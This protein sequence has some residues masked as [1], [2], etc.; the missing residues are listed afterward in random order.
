MTEDEDQWALD[1]LT[2]LALENPPLPGAVLSI[3]KAGSPLVWTLREGV[4][5]CY[6]K[7]VGAVPATVANKPTQSEVDKAKRVLRTKINNLVQEDKAKDISRRA[8]E[9]G[10][11]PLPEPPPPMLTTEQWVQKE[12]D[13]EMEAL[14]LVNDD[15]DL[16]SPVPASR[17]K[18]ALSAYLATGVV[19]STVIVGVSRIG[20][21]VVQAILSLL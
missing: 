9:L 20:Y 6:Y 4:L 16:P 19:V 17:S 12:T 10:V 5:E 3:W 21:V 2:K 11:E 13:K 7:P 8:N 1:R 18:P 15:E 14:G